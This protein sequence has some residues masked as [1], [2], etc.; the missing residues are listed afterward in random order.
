MR[1]RLFT[2]LS[3]ASLFLCVATCGLSVRSYA[4]IDGC[5]VVEHPSPSGRYWFVRSAAGNV[6][7]YGLTIIEYLETWEPVGKGGPLVRV[8]AARELWETVHGLSPEGRMPFAAIASV[9]AAGPIYHAAAG[10]SRR[11]RRRLRREIGLCPAC[12]YDLRASPGRCPECGAVPAK[13]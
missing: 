7:L 3:A 12:G 5:W 13:N 4:V 1:R 8:D 6:E 2:L 11:R 10:I 9:A